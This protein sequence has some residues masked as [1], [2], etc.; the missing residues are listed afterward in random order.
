VQRRAGNADSERGASAV[1]Y[2]LLI[3]AIAAVLVVVVLALGG[4][5]QSALDGACD[6]FGSTDNNA[7][8]PADCPS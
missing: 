1:E 7:A 4:L 6:D 2:A 5:V 3:S 8:T